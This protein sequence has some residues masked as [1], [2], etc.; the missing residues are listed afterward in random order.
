[1]SIDE[2]LVTVREVEAKEHR[3]NGAQRGKIVHDAFE[4]IFALVD[5]VINPPKMQMK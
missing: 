5:A 4:T 1:M 3:C 2:A